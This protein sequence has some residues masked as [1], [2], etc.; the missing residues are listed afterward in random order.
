M[1]KKRIGCFFLIFILCFSVSANAV[2]V[3]SKGA[4]CINADTGEVYFEKNADTLMTPA[5]LTKAMTLYIIFE[6]MAAGELTEDTPIPISANA[7]KLSR[8]GDASNIPLTSGS[9]VP[10]RSL[11]EA[12]VTASACAC[13]T[14]FAEYFSGNETAFAAL[15]TQKAQDMGIT[16]YFYDASGL[17]D[18]NL[19]SPRGLA[20]LVRTFI[21]TYPEIL[22]YTS[23]PSITF[24]GKKYNSTNLL[25]ATANTQ[26]SYPGVDGF[27]TGSTSKA[28]KCLVSTATRGSSR[29]VCVV[30][31]ASSN[32]YRYTDSRTLLDDAI[33]RIDYFENHLFSTDIRA[34]IDDKEI[35]CIYKYFGASGVMVLT[36]DL[37][38]YGFNITFD[39]TANAL[40]ITENPDKEAVSV[41]STKAPTWE[42]ERKIL[43][44]TAKVY[45]VK[46]DVST[47]LTNV[48]YTDRGFA[49][50]FGELSS[51]F[52]KTWDNN[53][54]SAYLIK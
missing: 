41:E 23:K 19:I 43:G 35:P 49:V 12:I 36:E 20:T 7:A 8:S 45:F 22:T 11:I 33:Y 53:T 29:I 5:S 51:F 52:E 21:N 10:A 17:S 40:Y 47:E 48:V 2:S 31:K 34:Y 15:M 42:I 37:D 24:N 18:K 13:C 54:R 14:V 44:N 32:H 38:F 50:G 28:G 30:M 1:L 4:L 27:K 46:D 16:A 39:E 3:N 25:L 26:Y 6:K 9:Y